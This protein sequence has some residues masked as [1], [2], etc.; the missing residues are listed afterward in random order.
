MGKGST[1]NVTLPIPALS[2]NS[3][4]SKEVTP[5]KSMLKGVRILVV[6]DEP[7]TREMIAHAVK[8]RGAKPVQ[9]D[10]AKKALQLLE[11]EPCDLVISD[12]GMPDLDGYAFIR[13]LRSLKSPA[14]KVPAIA[15]TAYAGEQ[16]RK[17]SIEA[18]FNTHIPKPITLTE[19]VRVIS[20]LIGE[21]RKLSA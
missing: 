21:R 3:D 5:G 11:Q 18:G 7:D 14:S 13:K 19:L 2:S 20:K 10:S 12:I 1:F 8:Q 16:D 4:A 17:L 15:L 9:A 6:E